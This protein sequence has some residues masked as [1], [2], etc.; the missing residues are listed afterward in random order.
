MVLNAARYQDFW[1]FLIPPSLQFKHLFF[2]FITSQWSIDLS[3]CWW[4]CLDSDAEFNVR[5]AVSMV[6]F[7]IMH[8]HFTSV[9]QRSY[10]LSYQWGSLWS[11]S[12]QLSSILYTITLIRNSFLT[13]I[14]PSTF[15]LIRP[16]DFT[17]YTKN[18]SQ[19]ILYSQFSYFP[20]YQ[21]SPPSNI[22]NLYLFQILVLLHFIA[23]HNCIR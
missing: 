1:A 7:S 20:H 2:V 6:K 22:I 10:W 15:N 17:A 8:S 16:R 14:L 11:F 4:S 13:A 19:Q 18:S 5:H 23:L 12:V 21:T 3:L 9:L